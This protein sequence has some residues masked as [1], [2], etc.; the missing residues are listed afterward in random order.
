MTGIKTIDLSY[1]Q[2]TE[3]EK[4]FLAGIACPKWDES[5][6][7][8]AI[9]SYVSYLGCAYKVIAEPSSD[10][11]FGQY[12]P[13]RSRSYALN[14]FACIRVLHELFMI[15]QIYVLIHVNFNNTAGQV[16][17]WDLETELRRSFAQLAYGDSTYSRVNIHGTGENMVRVAFAGLIEAF[18]NGELNGFLVD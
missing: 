14:P 17:V 15:E 4:A 9:G 8:A 16:W 3:R 6:E 10:P 11:K 12:P 1:E 5:S 18:N 13:P 7:G 2:A